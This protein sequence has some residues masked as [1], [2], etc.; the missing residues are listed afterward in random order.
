ML[1]HTFIYACICVYVLYVCERI[2]SFIHT[3]IHT[4]C[5]H[6]LTYTTKLTGGQNERKQEEKDGKFHRNE[7]NKRF[8]VLVFRSGS[9]PFLR[10]ER[11]LCSKLLEILMYIVFLFVCLFF[12]NLGKC[13]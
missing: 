10:I 6:L 7:T 9:F 11:K 1:L 8:Q 12:C 5:I 4:S 2:H 3:Y 13:L